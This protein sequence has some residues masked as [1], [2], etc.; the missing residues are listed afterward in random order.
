MNYKRREG[1]LGRD[2]TGIIELI[3]KKEQGKSM[4]VKTYIFTKEMAETTS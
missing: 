1:N 2:S 4:V 3:S